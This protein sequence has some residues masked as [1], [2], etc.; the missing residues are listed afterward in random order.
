MTTQ[1]TATEWREVPI[2]TLAHFSRGI[3]WRK[4]EE[5][6][7]GFLV[8]SIPNI[9][10]G[11]IDFDSKH[12]HYITKTIPESKKLRIGDIIFV[13]SSGSLHNVGRNAMVK[14]LPVGVAAFASFAFNARPDTSRVDPNFLY[15][16]CNSAQI[17]FSRYT[18]RAADGKFN[19]QLRDFEKNLKLNVPPLPEQKAI[20]RVLTTVQDAITEQG[21][22]IEKLK[23]LKRS[24]INHLFT[25]GTKGEKTKMTD[26]GEIPESWEIVE[27]STVCDKPQYG[28]TDSAATTGNVRFLR[29]TDITESGV[30]WNTVPFC[31]CPKPEKYLL[32]DGDIVFARIGA[33]TGKSYLLKNPNNAVYASYL[34]R[35]RAHHINK[36]FLYHY[37]QTDAYWKQIDSQKGTNLKGGVNGSILGRLLVPK[38]TTE[39]QETIAHTLTTIEDR[40]TAL[41]GKATVYRT[42]FKTLL[43]ELMSG[44]RRVL[45]PKVKEKQNPKEVFKD[46]VIQTYLI[47]NI[48]SPYTTHVRLEKMT[49][50]TRRFS[51]V[52]PTSRYGT[53]A[54]GPFDPLNKYKGGLRLALKKQYIEDGDQ[55]GYKVGRNAGQINY[56]YKKEVAAM[57]KVLDQ[58]NEK[59]DNELEVLATVDYSLWQL[60]NNKTKPTAR[61]VLDYIHSID[62]WKVKIER[63]S[64]DEA[65]IT[66]AM[67]QLRNLISS[68]LSYPAL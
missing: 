4:A 44:E 64:L 54:F 62:A 53:Y 18:K 36:A 43:H 3:S 42:L 12:N 9:K 8:V 7:D 20:A 28:Y 41:E 68:G 31:N 10:D 13:G 33:T 2:Y 26:I 16:L 61:L 14:E 11:R 38:C 1:S 40:I 50:F 30:D 57:Q 60:L 17:P 52:S 59:S 21:R 58:L 56:S 25:R 67:D 35:V 6:A 39:E 65:K 49:Y 48:P 63:L 45:L 47:K 37:F 5:S 29:I 32:K 46:A 19:F 22:L 55:Y 23:E 66:N 24:M 51:G 15:F 27:L 34:I